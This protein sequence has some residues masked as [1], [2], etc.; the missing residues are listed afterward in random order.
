MKD[1]SGRYVRR[2]TVFDSVLTEELQVNLILGK[3][4]VSYV[5]MSDL[6]YFTLVPPN[7]GV[8]KDFKIHIF[9]LIM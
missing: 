1:S 8:E 9:V 5:K 4:Q 3:S 6:L 7:T 2:F